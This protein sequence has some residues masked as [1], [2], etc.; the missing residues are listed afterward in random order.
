MSCLG[1]K[2]LLRRSVGAVCVSVGPSPRSVAAGRVPFACLGRFF[3][4]TLL[5]AQACHYG[6]GRGAPVVAWGDPEC[7]SDWQIYEACCFPMVDPTEGSRPHYMSWPP[8]WDPQN[9]AN[10]ARKA[11]RNASQC[12]R[13]FRDGFFQV[14]RK[15]PPPVK[16]L[17][18]GCQEV[19]P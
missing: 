16:E 19:T 14:D 4:R 6:F 9:V 1:V 13:P 5:V 7:W 10:A 2:Y 3:K 15:A 12:C 11:E 8:C 17:F 18:Q